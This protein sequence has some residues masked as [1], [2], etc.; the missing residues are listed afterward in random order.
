VPVQVMAELGEGKFQVNVVTE[1]ED[2]AAKG[3]K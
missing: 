3:R 2:T 1:P